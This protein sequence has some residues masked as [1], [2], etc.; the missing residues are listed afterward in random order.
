M[1][2]LGGEHMAVSETMTGRVGDQVEEIMRSMMSEGGHDN[3][4]I[5]GGIQQEPWMTALWVGIST[6]LRGRCDGEDL[7]I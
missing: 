7:K 1:S 5:M 6:K 3:S 4:Q 2:R